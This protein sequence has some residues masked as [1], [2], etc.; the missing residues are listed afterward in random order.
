M[1]VQHL[2]RT[3][4]GVCAVTLEREALD[5]GERG[6]FIATWAAETDGEVL[7]PGA[8][9]QIVKAYLAKLY[10]ERHDREPGSTTLNL[11]SHQLIDDL[12]GWTKLNWRPNA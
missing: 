3:P 1:N 2:V 4:H 7:E 10:R 8:Y 11:A 9:R 6:G 5:L 12:E